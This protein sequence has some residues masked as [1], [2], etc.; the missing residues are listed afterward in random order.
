M[1]DVGKRA[2]PS[3]LLSDAGSSAPWLRGKEGQREICW[4]FTIG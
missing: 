1:F 2:A 4:S 3:A